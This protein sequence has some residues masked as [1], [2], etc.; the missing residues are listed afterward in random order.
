MNTGS[1]EYVARDDALDRL[2][3]ATIVHSRERRR[4]SPAMVAAEEARE[5]AI[6]DFVRAHSK[7]VEYERR[8][9]AR[10]S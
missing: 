4:P 6:E 3:L 10:A 1:L 7:L 9:A 8:K 2:V 5:Q